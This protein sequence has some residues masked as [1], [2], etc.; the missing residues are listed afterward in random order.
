[1]SRYVVSISTADD[2]V[3]HKGTEDGMTPAK[4]IQALSDLD[5]DDMNDVAMGLLEAVDK[6][7]SDVEAAL[8]GPIGR[9]VR[10]FETV[11]EL[12]QP[13]VALDLLMRTHGNDVIVVHRPKRLDFFISTSHN[14]L[15]ETKQILTEL[16]DTLEDL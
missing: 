15:R 4:I 10:A 8:V 6:Q 12:D 14:T 1:M 9:V 2:D 16:L 5:L 11:D 7:A 3:T 13:D